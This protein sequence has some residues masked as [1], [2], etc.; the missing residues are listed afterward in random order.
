[1]RGDKEARHVRPRSSSGGMS[2]LD[3]VIAPGR[4]DQPRRFASRKPAL[5]W[6]ALG[7]QHHGDDRLTQPLAVM[8]VDRRPQLL[9]LAACR[10]LP[11]PRAH[12]KQ[13]ATNLTERTLHGWPQMATFGPGS[14]SCRTWLR[15][16][17]G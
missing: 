17:P 4:P 6:F 10:K 14:R 7:W 9:K 8:V 16:R 2:F 5:G 15:K 12:I 13:L 3:L 1:M 11:P